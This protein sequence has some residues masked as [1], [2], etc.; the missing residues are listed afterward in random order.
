MKN[1]KRVV[2]IVFLVMIVL[3]SNVYAAN[4]SLKAA[5]TADKQSVKPGEQ[6]IITVKLTDF[7]GS[8]SGVNSFKATLDYDKNIFEEIELEEGGN[9]SPNIDSLN[10]WDV[11]VYNPESGELTTTKGAFV[12]SAEDIMQIK[13]TV[14]SNVVI[15][16]TVVQLKNISASDGTDLVQMQDVSV[17]IQ[18]VSQQ[19]NPPQE[20]PED[21]SQDESEDSPKNPLEDEP[22]DDTTS[23]TDG[24]KDSNTVATGKLPQTGTSSVIAVAIAI[25]AINAVIAF[26]KYKDIK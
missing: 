13:L 25:I 19:E 1:I 21:P 9:L 17:T 7:Q 2:L 4:I 3:V 18:V 26:I 15:G 16:N 12:K 24:G 11:P 20:E 6:V 5:I 22:K 10:R 8:G 23:T 14:K